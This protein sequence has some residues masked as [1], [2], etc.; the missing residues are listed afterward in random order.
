MVYLRLHSFLNLAHL[1]S[2]EKAQPSYCFRARLP[3]CTRRAFRVKAL[4]NPKQKQF[5]RLIHLW[6]SR[7]T[8]SRLKS[9]SSRFRCMFSKIRRTL[10]FLSHVRMDR[11]DSDRS[12]VFRTCRIGNEYSSLLDFFQLS[13]LS[14]KPKIKR[15]STVKSMETWI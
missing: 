3:A 8:E 11:I 4:A 7:V 5:S 6:V 2:L 15:L 13:I 10:D 1:I 9:S 12:V 14:F